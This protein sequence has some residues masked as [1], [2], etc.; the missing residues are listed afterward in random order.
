[1][2][3]MLI[4]VIRE[5]QKI[6]DVVREY[7]QSPNLSKL[8]RAEGDAGLLQSTKEAFANATRHFSESC[9]ALQL[10][11]LVVNSSVCR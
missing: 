3:V 5:L 11:N 8:V 2:S 9:P 4:Q 7:Q 10:P 6:N 1:M